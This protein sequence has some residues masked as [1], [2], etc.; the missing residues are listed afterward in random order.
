M[1]DTPRT[2]LDR[3]APWDAQPEPEQQQ[4]AAVGL[5]HLAR[6]REPLDAL[7]TALLTD[8]YQITMAYSYW[9][10]GR[11]NGERAGCYGCCGLGRGCAQSR[12]LIGRCL[13]A[14]IMQCTT[15]SFARTRSA[16]STRSSVGL[17][18]A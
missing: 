15:S 2:F 10:N 5:A 12:R 4:A 18:N 7:S 17:K 9:F 3:R 1:V 6:S 11:H 13:S 8:M 16:G 14:Q